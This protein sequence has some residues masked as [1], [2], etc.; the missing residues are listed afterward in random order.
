MAQARLSQLP[1]RLLRWL[2]RDYQRTQGRTSSRHD[3]LVR[4]VAGDK[5]NLSQSLRTATRRAR[6]RSLPRRESGVR[7]SHGSRSSP[8][9]PADWRRHDQ[10]REGVDKP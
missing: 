6:H 9:G 10:R 2:Y 7:V 8:G 4:A 3:E 1:Q 5:G